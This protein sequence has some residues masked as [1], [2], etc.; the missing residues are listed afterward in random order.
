MPA[1]GLSLEWTGSQLA[2][3]GVAVSSRWQEAC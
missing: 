2:A 3:T 1:E